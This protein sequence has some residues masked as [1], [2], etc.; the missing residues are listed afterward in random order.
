M[1]ASW[2]TTPSTVTTTPSI[3]AL[4]PTTW[5]SWLEL[6][7]P[8]GDGRRS[9]R[10][11]P[12]HPG[13]NC[14]LF[15][16]LCKLA[17]GGSDEGL[18]TWART[19]NREFS[20]PLAR[21]LRF[22]ASGAVCVPLPGTLARPRASAGLALETGPHVGVKGGAYRWAQ[23]RHGVWCGAASRDSAQSDDRASRGPRLGRQ[24]ARHRW[25]RR[26]TPGPLWL[27]GA[28]TFRRRKVRRRAKVVARLL[29]CQYR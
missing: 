7:R 2:P 20:V 4:S 5:R 19:L 27:G 15:A 21:L 26:D 24:A 8:T 1:W 23:G 13:R 10:T 16:A 11:S 17:L 6:Y 25:Y 3:R 18:L 22:G 12:R 14:A 9:L 29:R 28:K